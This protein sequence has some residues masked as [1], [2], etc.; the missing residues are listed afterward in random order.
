LKGKETIMKKTLKKL[1]AS[2]LLMAV[3]LGSFHTNAQAANTCKSISGHLRG[4]AVTFEVTTGSGWLFGQ[5]LTLSQS[6]GVA[7]SGNYAFRSGTTYKTYGAYKVTIKRLSGKGAVPKSFVW[8][9]GSTKIKLGKKTKYQITVTPLTDS[10]YYN[11]VPHF[12]K[13]Q[14]KNQFDRNWKTTPI[15]NVKKTKNITLCRK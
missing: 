14:N 13:Y 7:Y 2:A 1:L 9:G 5:Y 10:Y 11:K 8:T 12:L 6:K 15:W 4:K 3:L